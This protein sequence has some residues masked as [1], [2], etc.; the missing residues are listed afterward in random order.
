[1]SNWM[2]V[3]L[4]LAVIVSVTVSAQEATSKKKVALEEASSKLVQLSTYIASMTR[5][6]AENSAA[7][8]SYSQSQ[9]Y[10]SLQGRISDLRETQN[11]T[12]ALIQSLNDVP[13][14]DDAA[15]DGLVANIDTAYGVGGDI[16]N[17]Q[18]LDQ[19]LSSV[20]GVESLTELV[21][22]SEVIAVEGVTVDQAGDGMAE[23][24]NIYQNI[25]MSPI[26]QDVMNVLHDDFRESSTTPDGGGFNEN[27]ATQI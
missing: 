26:Y 1:M 18:N 6:L 19:A 11:V 8:P 3:I 2:K 25:A 10:M 17:G 13:A 21:S 14:S 22:A 23:I 20:D 7:D 15:I 5:T 24:P 4:A 9:E 27:D 16:F 12:F